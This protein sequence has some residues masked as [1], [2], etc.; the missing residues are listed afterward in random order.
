MA[1]GAHASMSQP[2]LDLSG[3]DLDQADR[4]TYVLHQ[5]FRY[6]YDGPVHDLEHRLV[7]VPPARHGSMRR[8]LHSVQCS[9]PGART[10]SRR[11]RHGN[12]VVRV[13][14]GHVPRS[15]EFTVAAVVERGGP[16]VDARLPASALDDPRYLRPTRR[17]AA[18]PA[19]RALAAELRAESTDDRDFAHRCCARVRES[20]AYEFGRTS[21]STTAAEAFAVG[22][23]V[24]QD[25]AHVM[26][27]LCRAAGVPARYVSGH[28]LGEGGSHAWV[29]VVVPDGAAARAVAMDPCNGCRAG[30]RHVPV[31][32]GRDYGDV[33]PTSG[34]Y[35]GTASG[36]LT[37]SKR[38]GVVAA[39]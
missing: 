5:R 16:V 14:L 29:E 34:R 32:V 6:D 1:L 17:T 4:V 19:L 22:R 21:V 24:C 38:A 13:R 11:D 10:S 35:R 12:H 7:A 33:P 25:H 26:L 36:R 27:A 8:R 20:I 39:C 28:L 30:A 9:A 23:G 15:V 18:D 31:A 37:T 3:V 2:L